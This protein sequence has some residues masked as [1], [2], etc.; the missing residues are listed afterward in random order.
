MTVLVR[1]NRFSFLPLSART[2]C[3]HS[4]CRYCRDSKVTDLLHRGRAHLFAYEVKVAHTFLR[5][6]HSK[7]GFVHF[8]QP[9]VFPRLQPLQDLPVE[10]NSPVKL[11][12]EAA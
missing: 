9:A 11:F 6:S 1:N 4:Q 5:I 7:V 8:Q 10:Q 2:P 12:D 3:L